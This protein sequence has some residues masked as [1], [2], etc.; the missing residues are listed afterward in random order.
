M[1]QNNKNISIASVIKR[2]IT[3]FKCVFVIISVPGDHFKSNDL[4]IKNAFNETE[5]KKKEKTTNTPNLK[6]TTNTQV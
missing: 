3:I 2:H 6:S 1:K 4:L 5:K